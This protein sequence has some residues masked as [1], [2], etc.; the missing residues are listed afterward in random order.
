M[1]PTA[2]RRGEKLPDAQEKTIGTAEQRNGPFPRSGF[3]AR[4]I[5]AK[6]CWGGKALRAPGLS[7]A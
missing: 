5:M 1:R 6:S 7:A 3:G 4:A 2:P